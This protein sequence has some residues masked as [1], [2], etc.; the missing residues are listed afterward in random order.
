MENQPDADF[1][2]ISHR[3]IHGGFSKKKVYFF[4]LRKGGKDFS[5]TKKLR[6]QTFFI[7]TP[8]WGFMIQFDGP[9][10]FQMG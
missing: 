6:F 3:S 4:K 1:G 5:A 2:D 9:H 10:I 7:L 8:T